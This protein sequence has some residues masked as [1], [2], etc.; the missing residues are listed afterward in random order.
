MR[1]YTTPHPLSCGIDLPARTLDGWS[2]RQDGEVRLH[3]PRPARPDAL[4]KAIAPSRDAMVLTGAW[5]FPWY[6]LAALGAQAGLPLVLGPALSLH[7]LQGGQT[8]NAT[9]DSQNIAV[10]LRRRTPVRRTR[11]ALLAHLPNTQ[12]Q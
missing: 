3:R 8:T 4:R 10:R 7:A 5:R 2:R 12:S 9:I 11:A 1:C 6:W